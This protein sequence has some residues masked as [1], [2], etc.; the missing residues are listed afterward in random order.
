MHLTR[1]GVGKAQCRAMCVVMAASL[2][3]HMCDAGMS[4]H[5]HSQCLPLKVFP[6]GG[7]DVFEDLDS[8]RVAL[9]HAT[10]IYMLLSY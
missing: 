9:E 4:E 10:G 1:D 8:H 5:A 2:T 6:R 7:A 3:V